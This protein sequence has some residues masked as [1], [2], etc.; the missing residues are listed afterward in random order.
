[1]HWVCQKDAHIFFTVLVN[2]NALTFGLPSIYLIKSK[3]AEDQQA[4][5]QTV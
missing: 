5:Q 3:S 4:E 2:K 1:M